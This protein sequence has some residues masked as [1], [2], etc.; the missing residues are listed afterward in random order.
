VVKDGTSVGGASS[1]GDASSPG[2]GV[3]VGEGAAGRGG[4]GA[5]GGHTITVEIPIPSSGQQSHLSTP[6]ATTESISPISHTQLSSILNPPPPPLPNSVLSEVYSYNPHFTLE[7][8]NKFYEE[9]QNPQLLPPIIHRIQGLAVACL[10]GGHSVGVFSRLIDNLLGCGVL[11][12]IDLKRPPSILGGDGDEWINIG[13][14]L[15]KKKEKKKRKKRQEG[16]GEGEE[17]EDDEGNEEN[18]EEEEKEEDEGEKDDKKNDDGKTSGDGAGDN[19]GGRG[20]KAKDDDD[21]GMYI[22]PPKFPQAQRINQRFALMS[23]HHWSN[24]RTGNDLH[25]SLRVHSEINKVLSKCEYLQSMPV[26]VMTLAGGLHDARNRA[27]LVGRTPLESMDVLFS[28]VEGLVDNWIT[29]V[30]VGA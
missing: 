26:P 6:K 2:G 12:E 13:S 20:E 3:G 9:L 14:L 27:Y 11:G 7:N 1:N 30:C 21:D 18:G 5:G 19:S 28:E 24:Q 16:E 10:E 22:P 23:S 15:G 4:K 25:F 17:E 8:W 29:E